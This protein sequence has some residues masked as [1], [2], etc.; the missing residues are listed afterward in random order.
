MPVDADAI[1]AIDE[2]YAG[3]DLYQDKLPSKGSITAALH[4]LSR[5]QTSYDL[6][7]S[8]HV[9]D[10][11]SQITGLSAS[12][13]K[14]ILAEFGEVRILSAIGGRSNRGT[15]G[16][17]AKLFEVMKP[18]KLEQ[19]PASQRVDVL[20]VMQQ[21]LVVE[22]VARYFAIKRVKAMFDYNAATWLFIQT[23]L[24]NARASG[25]AGVVAEYLVGAKLEL[26]FP[27]KKVRNKRF[28][29]ADTQGGF[30]G[31][32]EIG[33][34]IFHVTVGPMP[35]LFVKCKT[36]LDQGLRVY[37]LVQESQVV[38][39]R[40]NMEM[41]AAG[42]ATVQSIESFVATNID[43]LSGFDGDKL[44]S[45]FRRLLEKYNERVGAV[46][47]DKSMLIEIPPNLD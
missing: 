36:N 8:S 26:K 47:L 29:I 7:V 35:E 17:V 43:E 39:T 6:N 15:R 38:G 33:N 20:R 19:L 32:F 12:T 45:G 28:S 42:R 10:G 18:L 37:L 4:V 46:E 21:R 41:L 2:W 30:S 13:V 23:I 5:L 9:S 24:E 25:K 16:D 22:Y 31:D 14:K 11:Q 1:H 34:T 27:D 40:Q 44:G 3:L